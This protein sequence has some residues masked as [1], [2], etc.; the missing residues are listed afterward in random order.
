MGSILKRDRFFF[1]NG[2]GIL[3]DK[4]AQVVH[5]VKDGEVEVEIRRHSPCGKCGKCDK[6]QDAR[7]KGKNPINA[8]VGDMV[9]IEKDTKDLVK[10][11]LL[12]YVLPLI[13][14]LFGYGVEGWLNSY[15]QISDTYT[16]LVPVAAGLLFMALTFMFIKV[17]DG[18]LKREQI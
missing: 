6:G 11:T 7:F 15:F 2:G 1:I 10:A 3:Y 17:S 5:I 8:H 16:L 14:L 4:Y 13:N 18:R 9:K 12:I